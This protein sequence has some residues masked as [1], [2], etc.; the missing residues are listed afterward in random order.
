MEESCV[1][2][3]NRREPTKVISSPDKL[4]SG[5]SLYFDS[6]DSGDR[7]AKFRTLIV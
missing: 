7:N 3:E 4:I 1:T 6:H 2:E 5:Y